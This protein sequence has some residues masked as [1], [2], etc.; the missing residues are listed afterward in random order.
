MLIRGWEVV[1]KTRTRA[2]SVL[3]GIGSLLLMV[4]LYIKTGPGVSWNQYP[5]EVKLIFITLG[6]FC[7]YFTWIGILGG[8]NTF[9]AIVGIL[10]SLSFLYV[11]I[12]GF[13]ITINSSDRSL[14]FLFIVFCIM[15]TMIG[16][17]W[18][19]GSIKFLQ[20]EGGDM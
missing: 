12:G 1:M 15:Y 18:M 8:L 17:S 3:F 7:V 9:L 10:C 13:F 20:K 4:S 2:L 14:S 16:L 11:G 19:R 5:D 6:F